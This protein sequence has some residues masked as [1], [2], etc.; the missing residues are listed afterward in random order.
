MTI[1]GIITSISDNVAKVKI[2]E[3][4]Y[5]AKI[6]DGNYKVGDYV[7]I[8]HQLVVQKIPKSEALESIRQWKEII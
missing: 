5:T 6:I 4:E 7:F 3:E 8:Q 2:L 1:P